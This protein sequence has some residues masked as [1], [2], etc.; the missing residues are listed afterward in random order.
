MAELS[1]IDGSYLHQQ[2]NSPRC[3]L[4]ERQ[5]FDEFEKL[6]YKKDRLL[7]VKEQILMRYL[8]LGWTEAHHPWSKKGHVSYSA[9]ELFDHVINVV[10]PLADTHKVPD[11]PPLELPGLP[12][13]LK[14]I[15]T[16]A[17]NCVDLE[18]SLGSE[19]R[20]FRL[21]ATKKRD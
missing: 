15:G 1:V 6:S 18:V 7:A 8:G 2:Y 13:N 5:A 14:H 19:E 4:T 21:K 3:W 20:E 17:Q 9:D 11:E 16:R 12:S 10:L